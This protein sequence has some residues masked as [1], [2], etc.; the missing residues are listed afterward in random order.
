MK[1]KEKEI[2]LIYKNLN[3]KIK[4]KKIKNLNMKIEYGK[5][6]VS[7]PLK[8]NLDKNKAESIAK[9]FIDEKYNWVLKAVEKTKKLEE[10]YALKNIGKNKEDYIKII[11]NIYKII[12]LKDKEFKKIQ[13]TNLGTINFK[14]LKQDYDNNLIYINEEKVVNVEDYIKKVLKQILIDIS[15]KLIKKW[16]IILNVKVEKLKITSGKGNWGSCNTK[17]AYINLNFN[18]IYKNISE[19][20]YVVLH[21]LCHLF[22]ANHGKEFKAMMTR[23]MPDWKERKRKLNEKI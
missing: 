11:G 16:E 19:I 21:E 12:Y 18:L 23:Y 13:M 7:I 2:D 8:K 1:E 22:Y 5:I 17:K 14:Y 9:K 15:E 6:Y 4:V 3:I 10:K 20:E